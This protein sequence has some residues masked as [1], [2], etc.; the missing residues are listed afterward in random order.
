MIPQLKY[1]LFIWLLNNAECFGFAKP[2]DREFVLG[3]I[4]FEIFFNESIDFAKYVAILLFSAKL[5]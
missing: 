3:R 5:F 1:I 2:L 4:D